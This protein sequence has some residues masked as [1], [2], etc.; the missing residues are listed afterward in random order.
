MNTVDQEIQLSSIFQVIWKRSTR[1]ILITATVMLAAGLYSLTIDNRYRG[2][3][4]LMMIKSK[5]GERSMMFPAIPMDT[6]NEM[7]VSDKVL[8]DMIEMYDLNEPPYNFKHVDE[9]DGRVTVEQKEGSALI[10]ISVE[11]EDPVTAANVANS[12]AQNAMEVNSKLHLEEKSNMRKL[13]ET[14][15][16]SVRSAAENYMQAYKETKIENKID[17]LQN[18]LSTNNTIIATLRQQRDTLIHSI[19]ELEVKADYFKEI[20]SSTDFQPNLKIE[21]SVQSDNAMENLLDQIAPDAPLKERMQFK[22][23]EETPNMVYQALLEEYMK[24]QVDLPGQRAKL[25]SI[26]KKIEEIEPIV[27]EQQER[28]F[29]MQIEEQEAKRLFDQTLEVLAG[30]EKNYEWAGTT[31]ASERQDLTIAYPAIPNDKKVYP[32]RSLIVL[33]S[34]MIAFLLVFAY[35]LLSDLYG[36]VSSDNPEA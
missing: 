35:F 24:L 11:L 1:I 17:L 33:L 22:Y 36:M 21:R 14:E 6:F 15:L 29:A 31:V 20:F 3:V 9:L 28:L 7:V 34:G 23:E 10:R 2:E 16:S 8:S 30:I 25:E 12:I 18:E 4:D 26:D 27:R 13:M 19:R 32:Q 5:V